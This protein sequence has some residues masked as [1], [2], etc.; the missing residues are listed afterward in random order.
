M[1]SRGSRG[2]RR[3]KHVVTGLALALVAVFVTAC[4]TDNGATG[5]TL[6]YGYDFDAQWTNTFDV[7]KSQGDCDQVITY[8]IYDTL[9]HKTAGGELRPGL[10][11]AW[12]LPAAA[13][14]HE[15][16]L[17]LRPGLTFSN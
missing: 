11:S 17:T 15:L 4:G 14:G 16:D 3:S 6:R 8:F 2:T 12:E 13:N 1:R 5:G 10:A 7:S 9:L